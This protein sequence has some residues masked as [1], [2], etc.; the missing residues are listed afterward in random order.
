MCTDSRLGGE[1]MT[2]WERRRRR[3]RHSTQVTGEEGRW[4][5][6]RFKKSPRWEKNGEGGKDFRRSLSAD[7]AAAAKRKEK[8]GALKKTLAAV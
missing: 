3:D 4:R 2:R 5:R 7:L 1:G 6:R 8:G